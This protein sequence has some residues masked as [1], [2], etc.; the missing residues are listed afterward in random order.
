MA[1]YKRG[2]VNDDDLKREIWTLRPASDVNRLMRGEIK[3]RVPPAV[4]KRN[5]NAAWGVRSKL[6]NEALR[7][8]LGPK[9]GKS[10]EANN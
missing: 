6:I 9:T 3:K 5:P 10:N 8:F 2:M 1:Y 4:L 7:A